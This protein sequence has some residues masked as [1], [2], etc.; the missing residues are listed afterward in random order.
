VQRRDNPKYEKRNFYKRR[1]DKNHA[2]PPIV[3]HANKTYRQ[4][5]ALILTHVDILNL[6]L[7][8]KYE[9]ITIHMEDWVENSEDI[10]PLKT[11]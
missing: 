9:T 7:K 4:P 10:D 2:S 6:Y 8:D 3:G 11:D 1:D 5:L